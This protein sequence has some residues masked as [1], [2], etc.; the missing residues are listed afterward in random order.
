[1]KQK[2]IVAGAGAVGCFLAGRLSGAGMETLLLARGERLGQ[3][4]KN[5]LEIEIDGE[6]SA[7][8]V[9]VI[10]CCQDAGI[11]DIAIICTK[12]ADVESA[13]D[14]LSF[15][16]GPRTA[17]LT[18]Q[19]GVD[20]PRQIASKFPSSPVVAARLHGF[21]ELHGLR[22]HH[23]GVRPSVVFGQVSG[24]VTDAIQRVAKILEIAGVGAKV[25][26]DIEADL[27]EKLVLASSL[28]GS[29]AATGLDVGGLRRNQAGWAL[30]QGAVQEAVAVAHARNVRLPKGCAARTLAFIAEFPT[31]ATTSMHRDLEARR[32]SE[33]ESLTGA[34][35]RMAA[36]CG[37]SVPVHWEIEK[38]IRQRGL[39]G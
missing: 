19:N 21:F 36:E 17:I 35:I 25:S 30:L 13:M 32:P 6:V 29:G 33:Y 5:A 9:Q 7:V 14:R 4:S 39:L 12:A 23:V 22:V 8:P 15:T 31:H 2:L 20:A 1:M 27:W 18:L 26:P 11:V 34:M 16:I 24:E 10:D 28:G 38:R 37:V 3:L